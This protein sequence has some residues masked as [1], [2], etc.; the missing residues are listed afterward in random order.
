MSKEN[1]GEHDIIQVCIEF[2]LRFRHTTQGDVDWEVGR[3]IVMPSEVCGGKTLLQKSSHHATVFDVLY[4]W[5][6]ALQGFLDSNVQDF[7]DCC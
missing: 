3:S 5:A 4:L 7:Y 2:A 1:I 6:G